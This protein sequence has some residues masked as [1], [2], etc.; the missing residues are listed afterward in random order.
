MLPVAET[1]F[2]LSLGILLYTYVG[3]ALILLILTSVK[4]WIKST[5]LPDTI[6]YEAVT[7]VV[8]AYNEENFI[9]EKINNCLSLDYP[10]D[11]IKFIF[12]TDG[13][14]D[15][16]TAI[17]KKFSSIFN[18]HNDERRGKVAAVNRAMNMVDT[19]YVIFSDANTLL[20][21]NSILEMMKHYSDEKVGGVAG[22]KKVIPGNANN[23]VGK[24]EGLYW[25]YESFLKKLDSRMYSVVGAAGELFSMRTELY[26][27]IS[28]DT[29]LDDFVQSLTLCS[30]G[31]VVR[32]EPDAFSQEQASVSIKDEM[33][34]KVRISAGGF[35]AMI[36]LKN[37]FNVFR[38]PVL[39]F[40][41]ISHR[42][43]RWTLAPLA[44][45]ALFLASIAAWYLGGHI[46]YGYFA[47]AQALCYAFAV[48]GWLMAAS[49]RQPG[50]FYLPFYFTFMHLCVFGG[51][52]RFV[53]G[54]QTANWKKA[55]R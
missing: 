43:F 14:T 4:K 10:G 24:G 28:D 48:A 54:K 52:A 39:S 9:E 36:L 27:Q 41:Y 22:E 44:L 18:L 32:Y 47:L 50:P 23:S 19:P 55:V 16:T 2:W 34:R 8:A 46:F 51:F 25:R 45:I 37:L 21:R 35:Q 7:L 5:T 20:N 12:V 49:D 11:K 13:S 33:E 15:N 31:Y 53:L 1:I 29:I 30:N 3:Y 42:V 38:Y 17:I 40:Q 26:T 6:K